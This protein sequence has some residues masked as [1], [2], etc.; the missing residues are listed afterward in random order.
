MDGA[1]DRF[2]CSGCEVAAAI[3]S[4]A[5]LQAYY[6]ERTA[7]P[8][9]PARVDADWTAVPLEEHPGGQVECRLAVD[10]L[11]CASC[12]WVVEE[13]GHRIQGVD[14]MRVDL[15]SARLRVSF[16]PERVRLSQ[17][18]E[19]LATLASAVSM[20]SSA[21]AWASASTMSTP[22]MIGFTGK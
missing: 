4:G 17:V 9:R 10:G 11:R 18:A 3:I 12:V 14:E 19:K 20:A 13:M 6:Q 15:A 7:F 8:P 1:V 5:G 2:C 22:G 21:V 16:D